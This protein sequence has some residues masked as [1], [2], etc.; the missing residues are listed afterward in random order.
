MH[1]NERPHRDGNGFVSGDSFDRSKPA[2]LVTFVLFSVRPL[3]ATV[4][5]LVTF[6]TFDTFAAVASATFCW[7]SVRGGRGTSPRYR[8]A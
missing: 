1:A 8:P 6:V 4:R 3:F 5:V 2:T 7:A